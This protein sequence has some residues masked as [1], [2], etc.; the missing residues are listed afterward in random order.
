MQQQNIKEIA[1]KETPLFPNH[2]I[3]FGH[4]NVDFFLRLE[5]CFF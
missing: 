4:V 5:I 3:P 2:K 1:L